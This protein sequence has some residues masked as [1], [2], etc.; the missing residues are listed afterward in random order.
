MGKF[1]EV[2]SES[3]I[4]RCYILIIVTVGTHKL[5]F[6]RLL[7]KI[8]SLIEEK[9]IKADEV[10]AQIGYSTYDPKLYKFERFIEQDEF[11]KLIQKSDIVITH[12]GTGSIVNSIRNNKKVIAVP[13]RAKFHEHV[14]DHQIEI[15]QHFVETGHIIVVN[16]ID[17]L[18]EAL[19]NIE[20]F[21]PKEFV[22]GNEKIRKVL[23]DFIENI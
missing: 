6:N 4:W 2:L 10:F 18:K 13:R 14:D 19:M 1:V 12:G 11:I 20:N 17:D 22:S 16:D 9:I 21:T 8:D 15:V 7:E 3:S 23:E 5:S